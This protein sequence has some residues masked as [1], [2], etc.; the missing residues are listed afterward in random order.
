MLDLAHAAVRPGITTDE[1][2]RVVHE[3]TLEAGGYPSPYNYFSFPKS[4]CT[5]VN[6]VGDARTRFWPAR[7]WWRRVVLGR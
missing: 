7:A 4:V 2:D 3:A 1:L 6:E 5:S